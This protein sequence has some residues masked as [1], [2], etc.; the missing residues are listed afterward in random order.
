MSTR[1]GDVARMLQ[2]GW[3]SEDPATS[4]FA[5]ANKCSGKGLVPEQQHAR[6]V[7]YPD[8][9]KPTCSAPLKLNS[10]TRSLIVAA[11][12]LKKYLTLLG[13]PAAAD[14]CVLVT[15]V[16]EERMGTAPRSSKR[17]PCTPTRVG[18]CEPRDGL[19]PRWPHFR[20]VNLDQVVT[21][22]KFRV[23]R[24]AGAHLDKAVAKSFEM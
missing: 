12:W 22:T 8:R 19:K 10:L 24:T 14:A 5:K 13:K 11:G 9:L 20:V 23:L 2:A 21:H 15:E 7:P 3:T 17:A 6:A 1:C 4:S 16:I 18:P